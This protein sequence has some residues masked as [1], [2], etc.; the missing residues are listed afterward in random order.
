MPEI[1]TNTS[2]LQYLHQL[3]LLGILPQLS[4][5][6]LVPTA[7]LAE[8]E[9][10]RLLGVNAPDVRSIPWVEIRQPVASHLAALVHDLGTGETETI[11]LG[12]EIT[13]SVV[14]LDD[15]LARRAAQALGLRFTGT[16]GVLLDAKRAGLV[17][18]VKPM[19]DRLHSLG[20]R[21]SRATRETVL[22]LACE[23]DT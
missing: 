6:I 15:L 14:L 9:A 1:V 20:F 7:V 12:L 16:L 3:D 11:L 23:D 2:P 4:G 13:D 19:M 21:L 22:Q 17:A 5:R 18:S 10:G 8:L